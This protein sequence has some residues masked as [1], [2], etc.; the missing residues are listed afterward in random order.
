MNKAPKE[1]S[2]QIKRR[3]GFQRSY[4]A[5]TAKYGDNLPRRVRR[6]IA[7]DTWRELEAK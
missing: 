1:P 7:W 3:E 5:I 2:R 6:R 4:K